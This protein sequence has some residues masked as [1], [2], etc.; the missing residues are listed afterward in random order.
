[1]KLVLTATVEIPDEYFAG[2]EAALKVRDAW[3][4]LKAA[5]AGSG[6]HHKATEE[7]QPGRLDGRGRP[8]GR[9]AGYKVKRRQQARKGGNSVSESHAD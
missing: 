5:L 6:L 9:R 7:Q 4:T 1:M 2:A 8:R 3:D